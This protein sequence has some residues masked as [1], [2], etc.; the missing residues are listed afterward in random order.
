MPVTL[1]RAV[2]RSRGASGSK[3][4]PSW[5]RMAEIAA[6]IP[7]TR[8]RGQ[9]GHTQGMGSAKYLIEESGT[10]TRLCHALMH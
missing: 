9:A 7:C 4:Q 5:T 8:G 2:C 6:L 1:K 10:P 3:G